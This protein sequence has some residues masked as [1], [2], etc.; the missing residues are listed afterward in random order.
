MSEEDFQN[1][2][3]SVMESMLKDAIA[4]TTKLFEN[5]VDELKTEISQIKKEN[6]DLKSKCSQ[7]QVVQSHPV[8]QSNEETVD[9]ERSEGSGKCDS[10]VQCGEYEARFGLHKH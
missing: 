10:G 1:K 2:Y 5:M 7:F 8:E 9:P 4:K 3:A 6:E